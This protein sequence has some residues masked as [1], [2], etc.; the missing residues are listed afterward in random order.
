MDKLG[1]DYVYADKLYPGVVFVMISGIG[2]IEA[3]FIFAK[4]GSLLPKISPGRFIYLEEIL[5]LWY[6]YRAM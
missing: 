5:P 3:G 6:A 4:A 1:L 2:R